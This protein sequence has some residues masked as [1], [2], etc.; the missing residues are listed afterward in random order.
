MEKANGVIV[1]AHTNIN[2]NRCRDYGHPTVHFRDVAE[3]WNVWL[4]RRFSIKTP[5]L[6]PRDVVMMLSL[7]K[8][9]REANCHTRDNLVDL[10]GYAALAEEV[11]RVPLVD[12]DGTDTSLCEHRSEYVDAVKVGG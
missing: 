10:V 1:E 3:T 5:L 6:E 8:V 9:C 11:D 7:V 2:G 12:N 4:H